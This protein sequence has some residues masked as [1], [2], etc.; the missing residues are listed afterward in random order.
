MMFSWNDL[1]R[2]WVGPC[3]I[4]CLSNIAQGARGLCRQSPKTHGNYQN[5]NTTI[6]A[7]RFF[8]S[9]YL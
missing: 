2:I 3:N 8:T 7:R 5:K 1:G 6:V 4:N 9:R